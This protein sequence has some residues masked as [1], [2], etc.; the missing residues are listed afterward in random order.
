ME[1]KLVETF[2]K[3]KPGGFFVIPESEPTFSAALATDFLIE[4]LGLKE[5]GYIKIL[6]RPLTIY[7]VDGSF[8]HALRI[9]GRED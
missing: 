7:V 5:I 1:L 2:F 4:Y 3:K 6:D 8:K 9:F